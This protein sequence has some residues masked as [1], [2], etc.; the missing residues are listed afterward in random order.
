MSLLEQGLIG[1]NFIK[2][3][4]KEIFRFQYHKLD[5]GNK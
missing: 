5:G 3:I 1:Y 4:D 2:R